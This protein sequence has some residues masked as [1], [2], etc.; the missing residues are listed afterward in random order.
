[1]SKIKIKWKDLETTIN[2]PWQGKIGITFLLTL[3]AMICDAAGFAELVCKAN[4]IT[5]F[6]DIFNIDNIITTI[7]IILG[8]A[9]AFDVS[10]I[11]IGYA[12]CLIKHGLASTSYDKEK[13][14]KDTYF[15]EHKPPLIWLVLVFAGAAFIAGFVINLIM[16]LN[17]I[18]STDYAGGYEN[19]PYFMMI[20][21]LI[22]SLVTLSA[23]CLSCDPYIFDL[24]NVSKRL[25][26]L[27]TQEAN[28]KAIIKGYEDENNE[29][30]N[31]A[32]VNNNDDNNI[33][34]IDK[35]KTMIFEQ[36]DAYVDDYVLKMQNKTN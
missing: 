10:P 26:I 20:L 32:N 18:D 2:M 22:T 29:L 16:R 15:K 6:I 36:I 34:L 4:G 3:I 14:S 24:H 19:F 9:V 28:L 1:M 11:F 25:A 35:W 12:L 21:P 7:P 31:N 30:Y 17:Q 8:L 23:G 5:D 13:D 33:D 27:Q